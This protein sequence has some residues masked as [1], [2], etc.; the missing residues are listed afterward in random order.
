MCG[1]TFPFHARAN[2]MQWRR[3]EKRGTSAKR[4]RGNHSNRCSPL[5]DSS[6]HPV[7]LHY[8]RLIDLKPPPY[9]GALH[10]DGMLSPSWRKRAKP[11]LPRC[12]PRVPRIVHFIWLGSPVSQ[13]IA[14]N[15]MSFATI[16]PS[17]RVLL[18]LEHQSRALP[19]HGM[20]SSDNVT[21][22]PAGPIELVRISDFAANF[23][24]W[25][26]IEREDPVR[27]SG[28]SNYLRLEVLRLFGGIYTD[29]DG[30]AE[31]PFDD[32]DDLFRRAFVVHGGNIC[33]CMFGFGQHSPFLR[34]ALSAAAEACDKFRKCVNGPGNG[35][36]F[37]T[38]AIEAYQPE[39]V[40]FI[41][42]VHLTSSH[43]SQPR[44]T[45]HTFEGSWNPSHR[46][47]LAVCP[48]GADKCRALELRL[49]RGESSAVV[50]IAALLLL[51]LALVLLAMRWLTRR[52]R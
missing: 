6:Q 7:R 48:L 45:Y 51:P 42:G 9:R 27:L 31:R 19:V 5:P 23:S 39:D 28:K 11:R 15:I 34:F 33:N 24:T 50:G 10:N 1:C 25:R 35:P 38:A 41:W 4:V 8:G 17:W 12:E 3:H 49:Q 36:G 26:H 47:W 40:V 21:R 30:V 20:F 43:P 16:N 52:S 18:W 13:K 32:F 37:L 44:V 46:L 29:T 2:K 14:R 22:R